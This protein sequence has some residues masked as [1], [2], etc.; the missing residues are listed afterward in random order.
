MPVTLSWTKSNH[1]IRAAPIIGKRNDCDCWI[2]KYVYDALN[3]ETAENWMDSSGVVTI[4]SLNY[5]Y[6]A[7]G[8][9]INTWD[10]ATYAG[11]ILWE[12]GQNPPYYTEVDAGGGALM[13]LFSKYDQ[14]GNRTQA[15]TMG[16]NL[17][18][19]YTYNSLNEMT[20][21]TQQDHYTNQT[22]VAPKRV[23]FGY[24]AAG[25]LTSINRYN[26]LDGSPSEVVA[27]SGYYYDQ[28]GRL[29]AINTSGAFTFNQGW[30][31][32]SSNRVITYGSTP[33][34]PTYYTYDNKD[35]FATVTGTRLK[36]TP[37]IQ[38]GN[39]T[40]QGSTVQAGNQIASD[41][42]YSYTYDNEGNEITRVTTATGTARVMTYDYRNRLT[43]VKDYPT[44]TIGGTPTDDVQ[45]Q[46]DPVNHLV[47][48][49]VYQNGALTRSEA[50]F[51]DGDQVLQEKVTVN[52]VTQMF[53]FLNGPAIDQVLAQEDMSQQLTSA[54]RV[55]WFVD[56]NEG[57]TRDLL[58]NT[59]ALVTNGHF[60]YDAFG[61]VIAGNTSLTV[62]QYAG[63]I[64]DA[65]TGLQYNGAQ[66][67]G[68]W[69]D[70]TTGR[71]MSQD[72]I[73]FAAGDYNL[74]RYV[75]N[76]PTNLIIRVGPTLSPL[77]LLSPKT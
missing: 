9:M 39:R 7:V 42:T 18:N 6:D 57:S 73:G 63:G 17:I 52:G 14:N 47:S 11:F 24:D 34:G 10:S 38:A 58:D 71:W 19:T 70:S 21:V 61:H 46:Y 30:V 2:I 4:K 43:E 62:F 69:Y 60:N 16:D 68:R 75:A 48:R 67:S 32:D 65:L 35:Q 13:V 15:W 20:S 1:Q 66:G 72:P 36:A 26:G 5:Q 53:R 44:S 59:G 31:Y 29:T 56:D 50:Y 49:T 27:N 28:A 37:S 8:N 40:S 77:V 33:D 23:D 12:D 3:R 51:Y 41:G 22:V 45:Y 55:L 76:N 64:F 54:N 25:E 74:R